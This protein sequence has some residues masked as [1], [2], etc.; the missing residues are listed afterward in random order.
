MPLPAALQAR[1]AKRG[2]IKTSEAENGKLELV[3]EHQNWTQ[4]NYYK[5]NAE[6][7]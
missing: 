5:L 6:R 4:S 2:L 3:S 1:L 7:F